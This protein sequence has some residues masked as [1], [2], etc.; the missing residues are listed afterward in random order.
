MYTKWIDEGRIYEDKSDGSKYKF[1]SDVNP[2]FRALCY[3][4]I[5]DSSSGTDSWR[6]IARNLHQKMNSG[7]EVNSAKVVH[8]MVAGI[9]TVCDEQDVE[10]MRQIM[11]CVQERKYSPLSIKTYAQGTHSIHNSAREE[12]MTD[13]SQIINDTKVVT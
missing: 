12:F 9:G 10:K 5:F 1:W 8:L 2:A 4:T 13:L 3:R 6:A 11:S 7:N